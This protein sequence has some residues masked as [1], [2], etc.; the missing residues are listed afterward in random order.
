MK[1]SELKT[2]GNYRLTPASWG[3]ESYIMIDED[4]AADAMKG[5][6][7]MDEA[8]NPDENENDKPEPVEIVTD[9][10]GNFFAITDPIYERSY[11]GKKSMIQDY[12]YSKCQNPDEARD[13]TVEL[14]GNWKTFDDE[15]EETN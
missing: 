15:E 9:D 12:M 13:G 11:S 6:F 5:S 8:P 2:I 3:S 10:K 4:V 14:Y 7:N 1:R